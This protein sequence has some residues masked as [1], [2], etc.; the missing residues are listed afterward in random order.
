MQII[1]DR[2]T[3]LPCSSLW[4]G[5]D[6]AH[7]RLL[8][9][10]HFSRKLL[11]NLRTSPSSLPP[12]IAFQSPSVCSSP[13]SPA[14]SYGHSSPEILPFFH[15]LS[16][17]LNK[18]AVVVPCVGSPVDS[19]WQ[20][21][22][23]GF[24]HLLFSRLDNAVL[25]SLLSIHISGG[26]TELQCKA[27]RAGIRRLDGVESVGLPLLRLLSGSC[28]EGFSE[29]CLGVLVHSVSPR[30]LSCCTGRQQFKCGLDRC[31]LWQSRI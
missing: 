2:A 25:C 12:A 29:Q 3:Y 7:W 4:C 14:C 28:R 10:H 9:R 13:T 8:A 22:H 6:R 31:S 5:E 24:L 17:L 15:F 30:F 1:H 16:P 23:W 18:R 21:M 20:L 27:A 26:S 11:S 19:C